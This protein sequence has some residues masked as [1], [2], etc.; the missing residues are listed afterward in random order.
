MLMKVRIENGTLEF[1]QVFFERSMRL[2]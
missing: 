1:I 2:V